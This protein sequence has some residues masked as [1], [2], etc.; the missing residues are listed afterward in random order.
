M[1]NRNDTALGSI[2]HQRVY[3]AE[4]VENISGSVEEPPLHACLYQARRESRCRELA[5]D[6]PCY[7][8]VSILRHELL[9]HA[10]PLCSGEARDMHALAGIAGHVHRFA[11]VLDQRRDVALLEG[12]AI[13]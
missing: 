9:E 10:P 6:R 1:S 2:A 4:L 11:K 8:N 12:A 3:R 5:Y 7:P 13:R